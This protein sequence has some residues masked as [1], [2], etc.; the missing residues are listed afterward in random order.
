MATKL[1]LQVQE[2][3]QMATVL[4]LSTSGIW[5]GLRDRFWVSSACP[6]ARLKKWTGLEDGRG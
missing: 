2:K 5:D 4:L 3:L 1:G 6:E